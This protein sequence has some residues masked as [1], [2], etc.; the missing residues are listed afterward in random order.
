VKKTILI[1]V[2][3]PT[4]NEERSIG[5]CL[6]AV[7]NQTFPQ[8]DYE[9]IVVDNNSTDKTTQIVSKIRVKI[10]SEKMQGYVFA[11]RKGCSRAKGEIIVI[12]D[13]DTLVR[14]DWLEKIY[15][16]FREDSQ[17]AYLGGKAIF[18]PKTFLSILI[19]PVWNLGCWL[20]GFGPGFNL[21]FR[22]RVY[23]EIGGFRKEVNFDT[24]VDFCLRARKEGKSVFLWDNP[25]VTSSRHLQGPK[26]FVYCLKGA[27]NIISLFLFGK[28]PFFQFGEVRK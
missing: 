6:T 4:Y 28:A 15:Q 11:L 24:D 25:V 7:K 12:T 21:A 5:Q 26:G 18:K 8:K 20:L 10:F 14:K 13:A 17:V 2:V 16:V 19:E 3:V 22:K 1:S 23:R 9:I 27:I